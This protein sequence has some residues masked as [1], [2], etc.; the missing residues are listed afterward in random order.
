M[1]K[2]K[3]DLPDESFFV[4]IAGDEPTVREQVQIAEIISSRRNQADMSQVQAK[5]RADYEDRKLF[6]IDTESGLKSAKVRAMLSTAETPEDEDA[7]LQQ[8]FGLAKDSDYF[9]DNR[10]RI[11]FTP[12]GGQKVGV[13]LQKN[14]LMDEEGFS[15][16][17]LADIA[18]IG[19]DIAASVYGTVKGAAL[20]TATLGPG[21][22]TFVGGA[23]GAGTASGGAKAAEEMLESML[24]VNRQTSGEIIKDVGIN[25]GVAAAGE[26]IIGGAIKIAKPFVKG[27]KGK[28][29]EGD[30]LT[31]VGMGLTGEKEAQRILAT[32]AQAI[33]DETGES[34]DD[35]LATLQDVSPLGF[36]E[37]R[38][39]FGGLAPTIETAG[40]SSLVAR[41]QK[42]TEKIRG[43]SKRLRDNYKALQDTFDLYKTQIGAQ[44][45]ESIPEE[46]AER[47]GAAMLAGVSARS[48]SLQ[49]AQ[50]EAQNAVISQIDDMAVEL[51]AALEKNQDIDQFIFTSIAKAVNNFD[52]VAGIKYAGIN[53]VV[54]DQVGDAKIFDTSALSAMRDILKDRFGAAIAS[55][56][57]LTASGRNEAKVAQAVIDGFGEL[58]EKASFTALYN[59][60][61]RMNAQKMLFTGNTGSA[62]FDEAVKVI[63]N[64]TSSASV[65]SAVRAFNKAAD[66]PLSAASIKMLDD[67]ANEL[68]AAR[69]FYEKGMRKI[70]NLENISGMKGLQNAI[71]EGNRTGS[72][73]V[74]NLMPKADFI[75]SIINNSDDAALKKT[76]S[77]IRTMS[78]KGEGTAIANQL[79]EKVAA[80]WLRDAV[81]KTAFK[82]DDPFAFKGAAFSDAVDR[83]GE[84]TGNALFGQAKYAEVKKLADQIRSTTIPGRTQTADIE[85]ALLSAR[86]SSAPNALVNA[87]QDVAKAQKEAYDFQ[88]NALRKKI[89]S[90]EGAGGLDAAR[91]I[92]TPATSATE[93]NTIMNVLDDAGREQVRQF[94]LSNLVKDFGVDALVDGKALQGMSKSFTKAAEGGKLRAVFG[95]QMGIDIEKFAK[96][97]AANAKTVQGGDLIAANIAASPIENIGSILRLGFVGRLL[98]S[99]PIYRRIVRDYERLSRGLP[100]KSKQELLGQIIG[101][102]LVQTPVQSLQGG[103]EQSS[104]ELQAVMESSGINDQLS[105]IQSRMQPPVSSSGIGQ[106]NVTS[107]LAQTTQ[108]TGQQ[109]SIRQQAAANPAVAQALGIQGPTAGL[110]GQS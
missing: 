75:K 106:V 74:E 30:E 61:K 12:E 81:S 4:E 62:I 38:V 109:P 73:N 44:A 39:G 56:V 31:T 98:D 95:K 80:E 46:V 43:G 27:L 45:G 50:E 33:A 79:K 36:G 68:P 10:G 48:K 66:E 63:D 87:L 42:I 72:L 52:E 67:A 5:A 57:G 69:G 23:L 64:M 77:V 20:G 54:N 86:A 14:T 22:G 88:S 16:Y 101:A 107:P 91:H 3:I 35:V 104:K 92:A 51:G 83:I 9:R 78:P 7:Q 90:A 84:K 49:I 94:Y 19:A 8:L 26:A 21:F 2:I 76:L 41:Q 71:I 58:P 60:R 1:G 40:G 32:K 47:A 55:D 85:K 13:D 102:A 34:V 97:L 59:L 17:D 6:D 108:P 103:I 29:L 89:A 24:G 28:G 25:F 37:S 110:L 93:I 70:Q 18:N 99:A 105:Q 65:K 96:V 11:V 100:A 82:S 15:R 53:K